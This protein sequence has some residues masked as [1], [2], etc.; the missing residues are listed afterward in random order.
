MH[1]VF[2]LRCK[3]GSGWI[4]V[5]RTKHR[6]D[7]GIGK[8]ER[9]ALNRLWMDDDVGIHE[10]EQV[11]VGL[12]CSQVSRGAGSTVLSRAQDGRSKASRGFCGVGIWRAVID[13]DD[14]FNAATIAQRNQ[15]RQRLFE[16]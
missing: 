5:I 13:N 3:S 16:I 4:F 10:P 11:A 7:G 2:V 14:F 15:R 6:V 9:N 1:Q 12:G 8:R